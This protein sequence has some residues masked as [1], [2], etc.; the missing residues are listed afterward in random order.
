MRVE[1]S[2]QR[3]RDFVARL[4]GG[5]RVSPRVTPVERVMRRAVVLQPLQR[6]TVQAWMLQ[7]VLPLQHMRVVERQSHSKHH[8]PTVRIERVLQLRERQQHATLRERLLQHT[9]TLLMR[10]ASVAPVARAMKQAQ[11]AAVATPGER[12][13]AWAPRAV[14]PVATTVLSPAGRSQAAEARRPVTPAGREPA[15]QR[16]SALPGLAQPLVLP[17]QEMSRVTD[18]VMQQLD[19]RLLSYRERTGQ[20]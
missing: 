17:P 13:S 19:R 12:S 7:P 18:H 5:A 2:H 11:P 20:V 16:P 10:H 9:T 8:G 14:P 4:R 1:P 6:V 3:H 15:A